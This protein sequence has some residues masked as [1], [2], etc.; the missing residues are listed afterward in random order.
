M[1]AAAVI[2]VADYIADDQCDLPVAEK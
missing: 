1:S 2:S